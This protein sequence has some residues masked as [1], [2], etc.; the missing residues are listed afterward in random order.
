[1]AEKCRVVPVCLWDDGVAGSHDKTGDWQQESW[2]AYD[3]RRDG[4]ASFG[5]ISVASDKSILLVPWVML[6]CS[7]GH[8]SAFKLN[9]QKRDSENLIGGKTWRQPDTG[10]GK[11]FAILSIL[12]YDCESATLLILLVFVFASLKFAVLIPETWVPD[13][14]PVLLKFPLTLG[15]VDFDF[16]WLQVRSWWSLCG[17]CDWKF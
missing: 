9:N 15:T 5:T 3:R 4:V 12:F 17:A 11:A 10:S 1:M 16:I 8:A 7:V 13:C 2:N 14:S 6:C